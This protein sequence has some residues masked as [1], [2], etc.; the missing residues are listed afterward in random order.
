MTADGPAAD[1]GP[2]AVGVLLAAGTSTR[3][4]DQNKLLA[5]LEGRPVVQHAAERLVESPVDEAAAV[6][7]HDADRVADA[8]A[9]LPV[10]T[11][12]NPDYR[13]GQ[14]TSVARGAAWA[15]DRDADAAVFALGD[16]P[17]VAPVI[18]ER[19]L[20]AADP[21][22]VVVPTY[23]GTRGNPVVFGADHLPALR[24]LDGDEGG[25]AVFADADVTRVPVDDPGVRRDVDTPADLDDIR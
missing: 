18:Y 4:G 13:Q 22:G 19:L 1:G 20:D 6:V 16:V 5:D 10:E 14:G 8:L 11:V 7:G 23:D 17:R 9:G 2:R 3:F 24:D 21:S 12:R 25:R 15:A